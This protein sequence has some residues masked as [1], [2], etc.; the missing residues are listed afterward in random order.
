MSL[1]TTAMNYLNFQC[2]LAKIYIRVIIVHELKV[3]AEWKNI[4]SQPLLLIVM[5]SL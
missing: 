2:F 4:L 3:F 5:L 1:D